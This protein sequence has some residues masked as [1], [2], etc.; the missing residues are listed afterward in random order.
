MRY[1]IQD[2]F[3]G[4]NIIKKG[5]TRYFKTLSEAINFLELLNNKGYNEEDNFFI[6]CEDEHGNNIPIED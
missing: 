2:Y 4:L 1:Y 5:Y 3:T 6:V